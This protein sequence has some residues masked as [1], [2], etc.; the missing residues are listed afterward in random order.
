MEHERRHR[1]PSVAATGFGSA[2]AV[3][4]AAMLSLVVWAELDT[5]ESALDEVARRADVLVRV[6]DAAGV[7]ASARSTSGVSLGEQWDYRKDER[8]FRGYRAQTDVAVRIEELPVLGRVISESAREAQ[9]TPSGPVWLVDPD[10]PARVQ[11]CRLAAEDARRKAETYAAALGLELGSV[12]SVWEPGTRPGRPEPSFES[13]GAQSRL[14]SAVDMPVESGAVDVS[15]T[16]NVV[17][18]L[19]EA[20]GPPP[21]ATQ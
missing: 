21:S 20:T 12:V 16:V 13:L 18:E 17:F 7:D 3:P 4:D 19:V 9:A 8:V 6:L 10:N 5:P 1:P 11:A 14:A 2:R 15:A